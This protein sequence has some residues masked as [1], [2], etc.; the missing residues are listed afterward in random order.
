MSHTLS[1]PKP[2]M[3]QPNRTNSAQPHR[4]TP[5]PPT[6]TPVSF[7]SRL[8]AWQLPN[9]TCCPSKISTYVAS[10][11]RSSTSRV[12][13]VRCPGAI[14]TPGAA[15]ST[16]VG[17]A[18]SVARVAC[19]ARTRRT[20]GP[21]TRPPPS[22][23]GERAAGHAPSRE[24]TSDRPTGGRYR[25]RLCLGKLCRRIERPH[26]NVVTAHFPAEP[27]LRAQTKGKSN[28]LEVFCSLIVKIANQT[29][30]D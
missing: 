7:S 16:R 17:S 21:P 26:L 2:L 23:G 27:N 5:G 20:P 22:R 6:D 11:L 29:P 18:S 19:R 8:R 4:V 1:P 28:V 15:V 9:A 30:S 25:R 13:D 14:Q 24:G 10:P 3:P 12:S